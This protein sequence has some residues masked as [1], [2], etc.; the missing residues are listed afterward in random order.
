[1]KRPTPKPAGIDRQQIRD[2]IEHLSRGFVR[3]R[4]QQNIS[5]IDPV[6]EQVGYAIGKRARFTGARAGDDQQRPGRGRYRGEL[7][8]IQFRWVINM[9][10]C[11]SWCALQRVLAGHCRL[12]C[13]REA[14]CSSADVDAR[15]GENFMLSEQQWNHRLVEAPVV[16]ARESR[17]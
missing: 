5:R 8:L 9:D 4:E 7:L 13:C 1:M 14:S 15:P 10:R 2:A 16:L 12:R 11:R 6:L 17:Q 3:E